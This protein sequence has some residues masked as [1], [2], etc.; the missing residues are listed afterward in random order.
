MAPNGDQTSSA[1][2]PARLS[3]HMLC[4]ELS[5]APAG[6]GWVRGGVRD[7]QVAPTLQGAGQLQFVGWAWQLSALP[8]PTPMSSS[9]HQRVQELFPTLCQ[10][11]DWVLGLLEKFCSARCSCPGPCVEL[12]FPSL[13]SSAYP[14]SPGILGFIPCGSSCFQSICLLAPPL[15]CCCWEIFKNTSDGITSLLYRLQRLHTAFA[16]EAAF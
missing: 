1:L 6:P 14:L 16:G 11:G 13:D 15:P 8:T 3:V 2:P 9:T 7:L 12:H 4:A 5:I 10:R